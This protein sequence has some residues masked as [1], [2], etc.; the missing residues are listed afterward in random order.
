M[1]LPYGAQITSTGIYLPEKCLT[2]KD[3]EKSMETTD[4]WIVKM[5]GISERRIVADDEHTTDMGIKA[6]EKCIAKIGMDPLDIDLVILAT[7][8]P[9]RLYS[10]SACVIQD[11]IGAKNAGAFDIEVACSGY[12]YSLTI[13]SQFI[14][15]GMYKNVLVIG[16][17]INS[18][19]LDWED[20]T[21]SILFGDGAAATMVSRCEPGTGVLECLLG[22]DGS[23][24]E[25]LYLPAGGSRMP[26]TH[27]TVDEKQHYMY[28]KGN[29]I[30]K[31][32]TRLVP[33]FM[34]EL[35]EKNNLTFDQIK[36]VIPH[37]ANIRIIQS[38]AKRFNCSMDKFYTNLDKYGN[39]VAA[40]IPIAFH[41]ALEDGLIERGDYVMFVGFGGG[42]TWGGNIIKW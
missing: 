14:K 29:D 28:M 6:A 19:F 34:N 4:E 36:L 16:S 10:A 25:K 7:Y 13:A 26:A 12:V 40:T 24:S 41:E 2:N 33:K 17:D 8:T 22:S 37:Q 32:S 38:I 15:S 39:T 21:I 9:D 23:G 1:A 42:L 35:L 31:W 20:R 5:T 3:L 27:K 11:K 30:F 18:R